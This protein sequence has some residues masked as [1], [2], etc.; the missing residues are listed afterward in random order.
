MNWI[1][2]IVSKK[3]IED[4]IEYNTVKSFQKALPHLEI[5]DINVTNLNNHINHLIHDFKLKKFIP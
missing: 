5:R 4:E 3:Y 2:W 1:S